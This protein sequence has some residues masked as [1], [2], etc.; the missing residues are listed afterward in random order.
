MQVAC[1]ADTSFYEAFSRTRRFCYQIYLQKRRKI[2]RKLKQLR[3]YESFYHYK[4]SSFESV[5]GITGNRRVQ[6]F[7]RRK[8]QSRRAHGA[9]VRHV[10]M[11]SRYRITTCVRRV[12]RVLAA[13]FAQKQKRVTGPYL[14]LPD[15]LLRILSCGITT[16]RSTYTVCVKHPKTSKIVSF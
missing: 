1:R 14:I 12:L 9:R 8:C 7:A 15:S 11:S 6:Q 10:S 16:Y 4:R 13:D 3:E 2:Y 5:T